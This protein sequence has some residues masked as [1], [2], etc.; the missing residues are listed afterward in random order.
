M[1]LVMDLIDLLG[2]L[3]IMV[4]ILS[5]NSKFFFQSEP[6]EWGFCAAVLSY[7]PFELCTI[8]TPNTLKS[9]YWSCWSEFQVFSKSLLN[10][11]GIELY[12][13]AAFLTDSAQL[14]CLLHSRQN[15][16]QTKHKSEINNFKWW[17]FTHLT[18]NIY[19]YNKK[20]SIVGDRSRGRPD[21]S[22]FNSYYTEV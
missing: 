3:S 6:S 13:G 9:S 21:G 14:T 4:W 10:F 5:M 17:L 12:H 20:L 8:D 18:L 2:L 22:L 1:V 7:S 16:K 19:I 11:W 15:W